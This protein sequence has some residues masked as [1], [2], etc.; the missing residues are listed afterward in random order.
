MVTRVAFKTKAEHS[1]CPPK[2]WAVMLVHNEV[3]L[4]ALVNISA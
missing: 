3:N 4:Q 2:D 1:K